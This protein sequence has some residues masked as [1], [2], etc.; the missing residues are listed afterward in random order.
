MVFTQDFI[1]NMANNP[2]NDFIIVFLNQFDTFLM[3]ML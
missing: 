3:S 1:Q 2:D